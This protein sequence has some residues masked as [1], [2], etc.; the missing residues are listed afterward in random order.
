MNVISKLHHAPSPLLRILVAALL[1][2]LIFA[3]SYAVFSHK[4]VTLDVDRDFEHG[5]LADTG[6]VAVGGTPLDAGDL[7]YQSPGA[8][9]VALTNAGDGPARVLLLGGPPFGEDIVMWWNFVGRSHEEVVRWRSAYQQ[10]MGFEAPE[11][12]S[13]LASAAAR[14]LRG[15]DDGALGSPVQ[16]ALLDALVGTAYDDGRA[17]PQFGDFPPDPKPPIPAPPL[18]NNVRLRPR[19]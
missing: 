10:E 16:G 19:G 12:G 14:A 18:P 3:G 2:T 13:P 4:T 5:V 1:M 11:D 15:D 7:W 17:F 9:T 6:D 8:D